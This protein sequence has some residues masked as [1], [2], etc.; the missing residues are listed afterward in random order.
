MK[1][2][3]LRRFLL[4]IPILFAVLTVVFSFLRLIPGDPVEA[5]LGEGARSADV[6]ALRKELFLDQPLYE[7]YVKYIRGIFQGDLGSSWNTRLPVA[8]SIA[9]R[10]PATL[11]LAAGG[12]IIAILISFPLGIFAAK[13]ANHLPDRITMI[14]SVAAGA[15]PHFWLAPLLILLFSI[16]LGWLPVSG[17]GTFLHL[18][19][20][21]LTL[22]LALTAILVRM[23]RSSLL[24]EL[25]S[26]Y[27][28]TARAKGCSEPRVF[29]IH[30]LRNAMLP[31]VTILGL[32]FGSLLTG[33]II[34]ET[35]F[36]WPGI[37]R[38]LIQA[39]Y[40]RDYPLVQGCILVFSGLYAVVNLAVDLLYG[41]LD[42]RIELK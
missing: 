13:H 29:R 35:I 28:R 18:I 5:M 10:L 23:I 31:V 7:Q 32:Q 37:G 30:A 15:L 3:F 19:L 1:L 14:L 25:Q 40:S 6:A 42:P 21:S 36:S 11:Q 20:P 26:D 41:A 4:L 17:R 12:M 16:F 33:A 2:Y 8:S 27:I 34:T 9:S 38:L 39:I 22:G 24:E